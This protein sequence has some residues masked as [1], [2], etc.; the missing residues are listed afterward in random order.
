MFNK[1]SNI[2]F[3]CIFSTWKFSLD[4][5]GTLLI[6]NRTVVFSLVK[7][8]FKK[9]NNKVQ[10]VLYSSFQFKIFFLNICWQENQNRIYFY[11]LWGGQQINKKKRKDWETSV[12][13]GFFSFFYKIICIIILPLTFQTRTGNEKI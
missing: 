2:I 7:Q 4:L 6:K 1:R 10:Y 3:D 5:P 13:N 12:N 9:W 8:I 11:F